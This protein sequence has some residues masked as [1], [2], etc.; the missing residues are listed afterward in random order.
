[1]NNFE[2]ETNACQ[3]ISSGN[4]QKFKM[5]MIEVLLSKNLEVSETCQKNYYKE[6]YGFTEEEWEEYK[7][8]EECKNSAANKAKVE[9][10]KT[11][12]SKAIEN[13]LKQLALDFPGVPFDADLFKSIVSKVVLKKTGKLIPLVDI[14]LDVAELKAAYAAGDYV[15]MGLSIGSIL[16]EIIPCAM[17]IDLGLDVASIGNILFKAY[18][19]LSELKTFLGV[20]STIFKAIFETID[21]L[22]LIDAL[23]WVKNNGA[24][25]GQFAISL[26]G[27]T[28]NEF[29]ELLATKSGKSWRTCGTAL[30]LDLE[31]GITIIYYIDSSGQPALLINLNGVHFK[32]RLK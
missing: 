9:K 26:G 8:D 4:Y 32:I 24:L 13:E 30:C 22:N 21:E 19:S 28:V 16:T 7:E 23:E 20:N 18:K 31:S 15:A 5:C 27:K 6:K 14:G 2:D 12:I 1:M 3:V 25:A 29:L 10:F 17:I 11:D